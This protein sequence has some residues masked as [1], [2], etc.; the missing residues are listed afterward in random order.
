VGV[1][2]FIEYHKESINENRSKF[3]LAEFVLF[4]VLILFG[5]IMLADAVSAAG[6]AAP[7]QTK[8][9]QDNITKVTT[10]TSL[11]QTNT[12]KLKLHSAGTIKPAGNGN[13]IVG[14]LK[15]PRLGVK[16]TIRSDTV[17]AYNAA[18]HYPQSAAFGQHG[19]CGLMSHRT[20]YSALFRHLDSL[21]VGDKVIITNLQKTKY[22]YSVTSNGKDIR[23]DYKT[24]PIKFANTGTARLLLVTCYPPGSAKAAFITHCRLISADYLPKVLSTTPKNMQI[25][26]SRTATI[27]IKFSE[28]IK[29]DRYSTKMRFKN[30]KTNKYVSISISIKG[31]MLYI[32]TSTKRSS[33][34][35]YQF[36][37][38]NESIQDYTGNYLKAKYTFKFKT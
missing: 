25:K 21:R 15:I 19:E 31:N 4:L 26:T 20:T 27:A 32:K 28:R 16:C 38:P 36:T 1:N 9:N 12:S 6:A 24:N 13:F 2:A 18:Y 7:S 3:K 23:W 34:T 8:I 11:S 10:Q 22:T 35:W 33:N 17:N 5:T 30:L 29:K 14:W 37:I